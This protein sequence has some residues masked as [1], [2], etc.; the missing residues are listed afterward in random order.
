[1]V[2]NASLITSTPLGTHAGASPDVL[3]E[4]SV[5]EMSDVIKRSSEKTISSTDLVDKFVE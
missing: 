5:E 1:M 3:T 4:T 2:F